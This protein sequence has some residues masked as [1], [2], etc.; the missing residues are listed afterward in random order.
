MTEFEHLPEFTRRIVNATAA[1]W[2]EHTSY[3]K[4]SFKSREEPVQETVE[5]MARLIHQLTD[6]NLEGHVAG[7]RWT[8]EMVL[9]EEL[10]FRRHGRYRH[11]SFAEVN[12]AIYGNDETMAKYVQGILLTHILW[13][14]HARSID[15]YRRG[16]AKNVDGYTHLEVGPGHGMLLHFAASDS[17]CSAVT[18]WDISPTSLEHTRECFRKLG[19]REPTLKECDVMV[20]QTDQTFDSIVISEVCEH[21][22]D[23]EGALRSLHSSLSDNGRIYINIPV[24]SPTIDHIFLWETPEAVFETI[25]KAGFTIEDSLLAASGGYTLERARRMATTISVGVFARRSA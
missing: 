20:A 19:A 16:L 22:E 15:F 14:N 13:E 1:A 24:N 5:T 17:R 4:K 3:L 25:E 12:A 18:G 6:G 10:H 8:C 11:S 21:L 23:P 7:Y 9:E 2:P